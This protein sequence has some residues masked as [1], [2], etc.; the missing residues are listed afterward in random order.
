MKTSQ[1]NIILDCYNK[2]RDARDSGIP[3]TNNTY[4][5]NKAKSIAWESG[6]VVRDQEL[7]EEALKQKII[8][9][10]NKNVGSEY[11]KDIDPDGCI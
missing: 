10:P 4:P 1:S 8:V 9:H 7:A 11:F 6:W 2:G 5:G 3:R